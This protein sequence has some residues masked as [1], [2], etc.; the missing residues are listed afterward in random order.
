M[1][2]LK[3]IIEENNTLSGRIFDIF[4]QCLIIL[5]LATFSIETLPDLN[6]T[7]K[8]ALRTIEVVTVIIFTIEYLLR[9]IVADNKIKFIFSFYGIIDLA[10]ILPFYVARGV[11]LRSIRIFRLF[12]L[13]RAFKILRYSKAI[14]RLK[15]AFTSIKEELILFLI[16]T[17]FVMFIGAVGIYYFE[18]SAQPDNFESVFHCLWWAVAT[19]TTVGY[20]DVYPVTVGG[21]I[22]SFIILMIGLGIIAVPTGLIASALTKTL[23]DEDK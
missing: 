7:T 20:G 14:Q 5:S 18:N 19:F 6:E 2:S 4:I 22:F 11:D 12:R 17:A 10:A 16:A 8:S 23:K 15:D 1:N 9:V 21:K 13:I 3:R